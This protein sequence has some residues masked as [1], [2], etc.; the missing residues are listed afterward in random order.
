[1]TLLIRIAIL[2]C[3]GINQAV[4]S[5]DVSPKTPVIGSTLNVREALDLL[6]AF[7]CFDVE[8]LRGDTLT[9]EQQL[10]RLLRHSSRCIDNPELPNH[11]HQL[12][13]NMSQQF[14]KPA[15]QA[16]DRPN[17]L[18]FRKPWLQARHFY[19]ED[20]IRP[21]D[22]PEITANVSSWKAYQEGI[23]FNPGHNGLFIGEWALSA[24][25]WFSVNIE[26]LLLV[27]EVGDTEL[28]L[29][30]GNIKFTLNNFELKVGRAHMYW[31]QTQSDARILLGINTRPLDIIQIGS[32]QFFILPW[33]FKYLGP[34]QYRLSLAKLD[35][36][37]IFP[38]PLLATGRLMFKPTKNVEVGITRSMEF[39]GDGAPSFFFLEPLAEFV[40]IRVDE[41]KFWSLPITR[42]KG[43][44]SSFNNNFLGWDIRWT[45][46][47]LRRSE[48]FVE[49]YDEDPLG[50]DGW[51]RNLGIHLGFW[52]P[53]LTRAGDWQLLF[54][55]GYSPRVNYH[56]GIFKSGLTNEMQILGFNHGPRTLNFLVKANKLFL[57]R[58][59]LTTTVATRIGLRNFADSSLEEVSYLVKG[60]MRY[61]LWRHLRFDFEFGLQHIDD[62]NFLDDNLFTVMADS[63]LN[64]TF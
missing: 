15:Q 59:L 12:I 48:L 10:A 21:V 16:T 44:G 3:I 64:Y 36:E 43:E 24:A 34:A 50:I 35:G 7:D 42:F 52:I 40:G 61:Q 17:K 57:P 30:S 58:T 27:R 19:F 56:H 53:R 33:I 26:P 13:V 8:V 22:Q 4:A 2:L 46:E 54:E 11:L 49:F 39:G 31:G 18:L 45:I 14:V 5:P 32:P 1:M 51:R 37:Q 6:V 55:A 63:R 28:D 29:H 38:H 47:S 9:T 41:G 60:G 25:R 23:K 20:D 62:F